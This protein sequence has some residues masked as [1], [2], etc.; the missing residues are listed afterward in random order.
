MEITELYKKVKN[1][2]V[3]ESRLSELR[4]QND[5]LTAKADALEK[6]MS[7]E[8]K[9]V[10]KLEKGGLASFFFELTGKKEQ[11]LDKEKLEAYEAKVKYDNACYQLT[12]NKREIESYE[13]KIRELTGCE[14]QYQNALANRK[15]ELRNST[16]EL[17]KLEEE[18]AS[19]QLCEKEIG[20]A[21]QAGKEAMKI[22]EKVK[23]KLGEADNWATFDMFSD[24][25][26][27]DVLKYEALDKVESLVGQLQIKLN[28]F[29][30]ELTDVKIQANI[31][32]SI[33][34]FLKTADYFF[35]N[36]FTDYEV[37]DKISAAKKQIDSTIKQIDDTIVHL[38]ELLESEQYKEK[39]TKE[40]IER[41][42]LES[43][44][45]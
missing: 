10:D 20:E 38:N 9:D 13:S 26:F 21:V 15:K 35:D 44:R 8:Q 39:K 16:P 12:E 4:S 27:A 25:M 45:R 40:E 37:K 30:T 31:Q 41:I 33:D 28:S 18:M 43:D 36:I 29:K 14:N 24:G 2:E 7:K 19:A 5:E 34:D 42:V 32:V 1:K 6:A 23:K 3:Y 22:A 17:I 11:K